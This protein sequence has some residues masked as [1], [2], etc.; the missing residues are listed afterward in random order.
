MIGKLVKG[1]GA[2][3][4]IDYLLDEEDQKGALRPH[5]RIIVGTFAGR[6]AREI[7]AE[8]GALHALRPLLAVYV[9]HEALRLPKGDADLTDEIWSQ[10]AERWAN[11][12]GFEDFLVVHHGDG[13]VHIAASRIKRD[14]TVVS[15]AQ[16]Y[17]RSEAI[18]RQIEI[19]F[20]LTVV[21]SSHL[22]NPDK[23]LTHHKAPD[24]G[25]LIYNEVSGELPP[26]MCVAALIDGIL[27]VSAT[28]S[29]LITRL[30]V[31]GVVVDPNISASG[32][33][34]GLAYE[35]DGI[36]ITSKAMGRGFT[37][38]NLQKRGLNYE[39]GRDDETL[40]AARS[41]CQAA[42]AEL[43]QGSGDSGGGSAGLP[44]IRQRVA[45][46]GSDDQ[47]QPVADQAGQRGA[48]SRN[49]L[50][51]L[52]NGDSD[53]SSLHASDDLD[54]L[55]YLAAA[56]T[57]RHR[58]QGSGF[59]GQPKCVAE[60]EGLAALERHLTNTLGRAGGQIGQFVRAV[61]AGRWQIMVSTPDTKGG[62]IERQTWTAHQM[63]E[64]KNIRWL[65]A[66]NANFADVYVRP[67][68]RRIIL[69]DNLNAGQIKRLQDMSFAPAVVL[70]TSIDNYQ[71]WIRLL[72]SEAPEPSPEVAKRASR[73]LT[74]AFGGDPAA[75]GAERFGRMPGFVNRKP[76]HDR[77]GK[78]PWVTL[79][80]ASGV[81]AAAGRILVARIEKA[82]QEAAERLR[83]AAD[84]RQVV[85]SEH[86]VDVSV[87][88]KALVLSGLEISMRE[89]SD[90]SVADFRACRFALKHGARPDDFADALLQYSSDIEGRHPATEDYI[91]RTVRKADA[92]DFVRR[93]QQNYEAD[94]AQSIL[95]ETDDK[96]G[97]E[98]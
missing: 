69:L 55:V 49:A 74:K 15:D 78:G 90:R 45:G 25:Q 17:Q 1:R 36:R 30:E 96:A 41:R 60:R 89:T 34:S 10:I 6:S 38:G 43:V 64:P 54:R 46:A 33:M 91:E 88:A 93:G 59:D 58:E 67:M 75:V 8:F 76:K 61:G 47:I 7:A 83:G 29:E 73:L 31:E 92:T 32:R 56:E 87:D 18:I 22:L 13:H 26:A 94:S 28:V 52:A 57:E 40:R 3:G 24:R 84:H 44:S 12:M 66:S 82:L 39:P 37:W 77:R 27:D 53:G 71:A 72:P 63:F 11:A 5:A 62:K 23:A 50:D 85:K 70:E 98:F 42:A 86:A 16:D 81:I 80:E 4:L 2:R 19:D 65:Q 21:E 97:P 20:K 79:K 68:D 51:N 14:G 48:V 35:L 9:A 95:Q